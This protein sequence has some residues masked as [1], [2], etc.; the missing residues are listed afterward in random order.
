MDCL[1]QIHV[2][3]IHGEAGYHSN[4]PGIGVFCRNGDA[5]LGAG[6]YANSEKVIPRKY[7]NYAIVGLQP[8]R[9]G[10][11]R[12]GGVIGV[13]DGYA[14]Q[15]GKPF[16]MAALLVSYQASFGELHFTVVP[17][18]KK[19]TPAVVQLSYTVRF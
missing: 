6:R 1:P 7:S 5:V 10:P 8:Y 19:V 13:V 4:V 9:I 16:P 2:A 14:Y 11:V 15:D 12:V 17:P 3:A 18:V